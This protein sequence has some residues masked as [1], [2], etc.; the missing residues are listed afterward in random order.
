M[1]K[2]ICMLVMMIGLIIFMLNKII[3]FVYIYFIVYSYTLIVQLR[4]CDLRGHFAQTHA[5]TLARYCARRSNYFYAP[6]TCEL[7]I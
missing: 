2:K 6:F 4:K 5:H 7:K 3:V 1:R